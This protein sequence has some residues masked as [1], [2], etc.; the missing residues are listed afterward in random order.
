[1]KKTIK[2]LKVTVVLIFSVLSFIA[3]D[4]D[5]NVIESDVLGKDNANFET[6][7]TVYPATAY[8]KKLDS[9]QVNGLPANLLG[10]YNDPAYGQT[11]AS[12]VAQVTPTTF[13]PDFGT[14]AEIDRV[15]ISIPYFSTQTDVDDEGNPVYKL[16]S[17]YGNPS[18]GIKLSIYQNNYFLRDFDP[19]STTNS[20]QNFYSNANNTTNSVLTGTGVVNFDDHIVTT[21]HE[22]PVFIPSE[23]PTETT[24]GTGEDEV[25][26]LSE[27]AYTVVL[28]SNE[29]K[30]YWTSTIISKQDDPVLSNANNF[31]NYFRGIYFKAEALGS[32]GNMILL[33][34]ASSNANITIHYS[35]DSTVEDGERVESTYVLNFTGNRLNTFIND[36]NQVSLQNGDKTLGDE[37]LYLKGTSG[38]MAVI[39]LFGNEDSN[40][41]EIA[42]ALEDF[43]DEYR[44]TDE[45]GDYIID[46]TTGNYLLKRLI[47]EA[48]LEVY[49]DETINIGSNNEDFHKYDRIYAYD[50]KN[51]IPTVDYLADQTRNNQSPFNSKFISLGQRDTISGKYKIRLTQH[52]N[53]ILLRDSTNTKIGLVLSTNV[54]ADYNPDTFIFSSAEILES[55]DD[56]IAIPTSALI[57]LRGTILHGSNENAPEE[58]R[59]KLKVFYTEPK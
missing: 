56:V 15:V 14:N 4:K 45:N 39:D 57:S 19:N 58:K 27:P 33:N 28:D 8:N 30:L 31:K 6:N 20:T 7:S 36:Y 47:N 2:A 34:L 48:H 21:I 22:E 37:K 42:D 46:N 41:N 52:L 13:N 51:S 49:E 40:N 25:T 17:L 5:F 29:D 59:L 11:I 43:I 53:N 18:E 16:D 23:A 32:D 9:L 54:N 3:C 55:D 1:M 26:T 10:V 44:Q 38:S 35:K 50:V 12:I 24:T